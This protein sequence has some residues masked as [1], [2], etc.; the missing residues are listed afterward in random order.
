MT[1]DVHFLLGKCVEL[2]IPS[3]R[4]L[5]PKDSVMIEGYLTIRLHYGFLKLE[6]PAYHSL[7]RQNILENFTVVQEPSQNIYLLRSW[8][9]EHH[10]C[11]HSTWP[12]ERFS[13]GLPIPRHPKK[14]R[15][16]KQLMEESSLL[17]IVLEI[18][19]IEG[20]S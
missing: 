12:V 2:S 20:I 5:D 16:I 8:P 15:A 18:S 1:S 6:T 7:D 17:L 9:S 10:E 4:L 14:L 3:G 11:A 13:G 19:L